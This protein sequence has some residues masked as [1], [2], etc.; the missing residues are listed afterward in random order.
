VTKLIRC[1]IYTRKSS[2]EGLEQSFNSLHAQREACEAYIKSQQHEGWQ[3]IPTLYDDGGF[4]GGN[5]QRPALIQLLTDM[6]AGQLDLI[7]VYKVDRLSRSLADFARLVE[8]FDK[9]NVSFVSVTQQFNTST[10]MGRLTLNV[11]LSFAQFEREVTG[12]R[13]R[14]KIAASKKK[15]IWMGGPLPLGYDTNDRSLVI[16]PDE[17]KTVQHIYQRYLTLG[18][19][20]Q[21]KNE[22]DI[23]GYVS[24][25]RPGTKRRNE[26][27]FSR[28]ALYTILKNPAYIGK[29]KHKDKIYEGL[30]EPIIEDETWNRVQ[31]QLSRNRLKKQHRTQAKEPSLLAGFLKDD[32]GNPMSPTHTKK[33]TRRYRYYISQ[34]VLQYKDAQA[35]SVLRIPANTLE[36][37][38]A[39]EIKM[40]LMDKNRML[41]L[42]QPDDIPTAKQRSLVRLAAEHSTVWDATPS[43]QQIKILSKWLKTVIVSRTQITINITTL[44]LFQWILNWRQD[45][46]PFPINPQ[47][48]E[49]ILK[50]PA[51]LKRCG[52]ETKLILEDNNR[53]A[54]THHASAQPL[55]VL[56]IRALQWNK[57]LMTGSSSSMTDL[58]KTEGASPRHMASTLKLAYL[59]PDIIEAILNEQIP[60][61]LSCVKLKNGFPL[62]WDEQRVLLGF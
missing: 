38:V 4:S 19:V 43:S 52:M 14:D 40:L 53:S 17:A 61:T 33:G 6:E 1:A 22:L 31:A 32:R 50:I 25:S 10:S 30:H 49:L 16:N 7:V 26:A 8:R 37:T 20:R 11:L 45:T 27:P 3:V 28:G 36:K 9:T 46:N 56:M 5:M 57:A 12:E 55:K 2:E 35:G 34:A 29:T 60:P 39:A 13:I 58:A 21:L 41:A 24:K 42:V 15:G 48:N 59:A 62:N 18:C 54:D 51:K 23:A 47:N 44:E